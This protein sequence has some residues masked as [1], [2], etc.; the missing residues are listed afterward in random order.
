MPPKSQTNP[1]LRQCS[2][3]SDTDVSVSRNANNLNSWDEN[4][5]GNNKV[6]QTS[7]QE[8]NLVPATETSQTRNDFAIKNQQKFAQDYQTP[9]NSNNS[10]SHNKNTNTQKQHAISRETMSKNELDMLD[11]E[12]EQCTS[13]ALKAVI[14]YVPSDDSK[15]CK[16]TDPKTGGCFKGG[17][18]RKLHIPD[19]KG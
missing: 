6:P 10:T 4:S 9:N 1:F 18:C 14:G 13:N 8:K 2:W 16:H 3:N 15:I 11:S 7:L 5:T 19:I 17:N 12:E